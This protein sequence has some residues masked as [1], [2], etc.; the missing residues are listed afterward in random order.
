MYE[1]NINKFI[2]EI[3]KIEM[4]AEEK[5][6]MDKKIYQYLK[7]R[8]SLSPYTPLNYSLHLLKRSV[9]LL[10]MLALTFSFSKPISAKALPGDTLYPIKI[11]HEEISSSIIKD[12]EEKASFEIKRTQER[13]KEVAQLAKEKRL[14]KEIEKKIVRKITEHL[15][16]AKKEIEDIRE[17]EPAKALVLNKELKTTVEKSVNTIK[18]IK[19]KRRKRKKEEKT[20]TQREEALNNTKEET[21]GNTPQEEIKKDNFEKKELKEEKEKTE[22]NNKAISLE[23]E[24][25]S[26]NKN[27]ENEEEIKEYKQKEE[28]NETK[29]KQNEEN[30][31]ELQLLIKNDNGENIVPQKQNSKIN[32]EK[33]LTKV[34]DNTT[35]VEQNIKEKTGEE[36]KKQ[37]EKEVVNNNLEN[38][39][40][41]GNEILDVLEQTL[42]ETQKDNQEILKEIIADNQKDLAKEKQE[43]KVEKGEKEKK[44]TGIE[45]KDIKI[46]EE[47]LQKEEKS[48][49]TDTEA[50]KTEK[51][52]IKKIQFLNI[53]IIENILT[54]KADNSKNEIEEENKIEQQEQDNNKEK[55]IL[56]N[57]NIQKDELLPSNESSKENHSLK[58]KEKSLTSNAVKNIVNETNIE[59]ELK[60]EKLREI[61]SL[62]KKLF[63]L[64]QESKKNL[65]DEE[66]R[67]ILDLV[68]KERFSKAIQWL[69]A[70]IEKRKTTLKIPL[71]LE[72]VSLTQ[73]KPVE[74]K[75]E[76]EVSQE[77]PKHEKE[78][79]SES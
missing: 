18:R 56:N 75:V 27:P 39:E 14:N 41:E 35:K 36:K 47:N 58:E 30:N 70:E 9:A 20:A 3:K 40:E 57:I 46:T 72:Q 62:E 6:M 42:V 44:E 37:E 61:F 43:K 5:A 49:N 16:E 17:K 13:V 19:I 24:K 74:D 69:R 78:K 8:G 21:Q 26:T 51:K 4:T 77:N 33:G 76:K 71:E 11:L 66:K 12:P 28:E 67:V 79:P 73:E 23:E 10:L 1:K 7:K 25:D 65:N 31:T 53:E 64:I 15:H 2:N 59:E 68:N 60:K 32:E 63:Y 22:Q 52:T 38:E 34:V 55:T 54:Q 45:E 29:I 48:V 50:K